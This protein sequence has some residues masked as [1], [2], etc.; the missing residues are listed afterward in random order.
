MTI[1]PDQ[2]TSKASSTRPVRKGSKGPTETTRLFIDV[3][4]AIRR[5]QNVSLTRYVE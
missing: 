2:N 3:N 5:T 1:K 4:E